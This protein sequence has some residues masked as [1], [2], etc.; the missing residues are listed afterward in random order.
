MNR[1][2]PEDAVGVGY[3]H[4]AVSHDLENLLSPVINLHDVDGVEIYY[5]AAIAKCFHL[6]ADFQVIEP[7]DK[8]ND[9]AI[10]AGLRGVIAL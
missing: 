8:S 5:N 9:T 6:T 2:R 4:T 3:F 1:C 7:A 10:V